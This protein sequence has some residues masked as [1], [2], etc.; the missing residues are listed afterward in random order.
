[1][2]GQFKAGLAAICVLWVSQQVLA[3]EQEVTTVNAID[4]TGSVVSMF[5]QQVS[6]TTLTCEV[7]QYGNPV[8]TGPVRIGDRINHAGK[9]IKVGIIEK[10]RF[11]R[12]SNTVARS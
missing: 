2:T 10:T 9:A 11:T 4:V 7:K 12:M 5:G 6:D 1:M 8:I 3:G